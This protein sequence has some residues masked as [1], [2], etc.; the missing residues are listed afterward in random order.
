MSVCF[1]GAV[2][3]SKI[4]NLSL[5]SDILEPQSIMGTGV[6]TAA[7]MKQPVLIVQNH[8]AQSENQPYD[9]W[10]RCNV[11]SC[12]LDRNEPSTDQ[13]AGAEFVCTPTV[14]TEVSLPPQ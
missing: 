7:L 14:T 8:P 13:F 12:Q 1:L 6:S 9:C 5:D 2:E 10:A 11:R 4:S 3:K